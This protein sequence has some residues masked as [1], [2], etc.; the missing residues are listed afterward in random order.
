MLQTIDR[1]GLR[2]I[3]ATLTLLTSATA[4]A[5]AFEAPVG[6]QD[7]EVVKQFDANAAQFQSLI[8]KA[9]Q[10]AESFGTA[11]VEERPAIQAEY[12]TVTEQ[13]EQSLEPLKRS[14]LAAYKVTGE[15]NKA[16]SDMLLRIAGT[17]MEK[18]NFQGILEITTPLIENGNE[19][20]GLFM[21][22]GMGAY[23]TNQFEFA[24]QYWT[25]SQEKGTLPAEFTRYFNSLDDLIVS[26]KNEQEVRRKD[27]AGEPLPIVSLETSDGE[28]IIEL[29]ENQAPET[30]GNFISLVEKGFYD[31]L[32]FHRVLPQ[33]MAQGGCPDGSGSGGPGYKIFCECYREDYRH[34]FA[35]TL[36]MAHAGKDT[37]GSQFFLTFLPTTHLDGKHTAF[38]RVV[39]GWDVLHKI[40]RIDPGQPGPEPDKIIR[41]KVLRKRNHEYVPNK[42]E[43]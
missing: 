8:T 26:W 7:E 5:S 31:G 22:A 33:F 25:K 32:S 4:V 42:V 19:S 30:V 23:G 43:G 6:V 10:L 18:D 9:N 24:K 15:S 36:S 11:S 37:G 12:K 3:L 29:F 27:A 38:G 41:A 2:L 1:N 34:H 16:V 21:V 35:G 17:E 39:E 28:I 13:I 14:A 40:R 20:D